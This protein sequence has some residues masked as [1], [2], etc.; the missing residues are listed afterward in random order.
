MDELGLDIDRYQT[1]LGTLAVHKL[2]KLAMDLVWAFIYHQRHL[3]AV[4]G[5]FECQLQGFV[6]NHAVIGINHRPR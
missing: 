5:D 1:Q 4:V 2:G 3:R 6:A